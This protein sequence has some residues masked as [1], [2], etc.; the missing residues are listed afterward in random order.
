MRGVW[1]PLV[2]ALGCSASET[3]E[4]GDGVVCGPDRIC[5]AVTWTFTAPATAPVE[6]SS[7]FCVDQSQVEGCAG[8]PDGTACSAVD[9]GSCHSGVCLPSECGNHRVDTGEECDDSNLE[10]GDAC[11]SRC[12]LEICGNEVVDAA[13]GELCDDGNL[14]DHDGCSST[15]QLETLDWYRVAPPA[16][17]YN[18]AAAFDVARDKVVMFNGDTGDIYEW[19]GVWRVASPPSKPSPRQLYAFTYAPDLGGV[20]LYGGEELGSGISGGLSSVYMWNGARWSVL[21]AG[22]TNKEHAMAYDARRKRLVVFGG[23]DEIAETTSRKVWEFDGTTWT[24]VTPVNAANAPPATRD[25][26]MAY[27]AKQGLIVL[28]VGPSVTEGTWEYD[29]TTWSRQTNTTVPSLNKSRLVYLAGLERVAL[30]GGIEQGSNAITSRIYLWNG[31]NWDLRGPFAGRERLRNAVSDDGRG[32]LISFGGCNAKDGS[33]NCTVVLGD[34]AFYDGSN[35]SVEQT[36]PGYEGVAAVNVGGKI[37]RIGGGNNFVPGGSNSTWELTRRGWTSFPD[38]PGTDDSPPPLSQPGMVHDVERNQLVLF[39]G[40]KSDGT[41]DN[42]TWL[43]TN[44]TWSVVQPSP[45]PPPRGSLSLAYHHASKL[46]V[47]YGGADVAAN[48]K[49]DTWVWNGT[50]WTEVTTPGP[51]PRYGAAIGYDH[52]HGLLVL[53][54]GSTITSKLGD[55]WV[56]DGTSWT[57]LTN[58]AGEQPPPSYFSS[59]TWDHAGRRLLLT[60]GAV[61]Q[62]D[63]WEWDGDATTSRWK[64]VSTLRIPPPRSVDIVVASLDGSGITTMGGETYPSGDPTSELWELRSSADRGSDGCKVSLDADG[65]LLTGC[66]DDDC[67]TVCTPVCPPDTSCPTTA[68][69]CGDNICSAV[70]SCQTCAADCPTCT[71]ICGDFVCDPSEVCPGDCP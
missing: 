43:R 12:R 42:R 9:A 58:R 65:D 23:R 57:E 30:Y 52:E 56:F 64:R 32:R 36:P 33:G 37:V 49:G 29:G 47:M 15:C 59:L 31:T 24:D 26:T 51:S 70:E 44:T 66:D 39:G 6:E 2:L 55:V 8:M 40:F 61:R 7:N 28:Y 48:L 16:P 41:I 54:G 35:W 27:D 17:S 67:W 45:S 10:P 71:S 21:P 19:D 50:A 60:G 14:A 22:P 3:V 38:G 20:V 13:Q 18:L 4:C 34:T 5:A 11:S 69:Q 63:T 1:L 53:F 25:S 46:T 68:P 62:F